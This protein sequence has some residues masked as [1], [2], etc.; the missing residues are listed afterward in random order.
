MQITE[1]ATPTPMAEPI[2]WLAEQRGY[3][4]GYNGIRDGRYEE[5]AAEVRRRDETAVQYLESHWRT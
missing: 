2:A 1:R 3:W 4:S 5:T